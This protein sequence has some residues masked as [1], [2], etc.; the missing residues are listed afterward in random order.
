MPVNEELPDYG[1]D[2]PAVN[3]L[4]TQAVEQVGKQA[5]EVLK[6]EAA[7]LLIETNLESEE[8]ALNLVQGGSLPEL[9]ESMGI[10]EVKLKDGSLVEVKRFYAPYISEERR[11]SAHAWMDE[12]GFGSLIKK[13][14]V[15]AIDRGDDLALLDLAKYLKDAK[16]DYSVEEGINYKTLESFVKGQYES[17]E[18]GAAKPPLDLF[19]IFVAKKAIIKGK[20]KSLPRKYSKKNSKKK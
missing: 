9:L 8:K 1:A 15:V 5:E 13:T 6:R 18:E 10:A 3:Q 2:A 11:E 4:S 7:I 19:G 12:H 20:V 14:V 17:T 16:Y